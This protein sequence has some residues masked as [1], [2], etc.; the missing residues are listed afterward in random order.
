MPS[1][2]ATFLISQFPASYKPT[3]ARITELLGLND[4]NTTLASLVNVVNQPEAA[5]L[6]NEIMAMHGGKIVMVK[7]WT[8]LRVPGGELWETGGGKQ[9]AGFAVPDAVRD[10][11]KPEPR[12]DPFEF[13]DDAFE[14]DYGQM[15]GEPF[16]ALDGDFDR[17]NSKSRSLSRS[18]PSRSRSPSLA[19]SP[20]KKKYTAK[21]SLPLK[22]KSE[23][24]HV[25]EDEEEPAPK[26]AR[27][28]NS[29]TSAPPA[30]SK[31]K[32]PSPEP[33]SNSKGKQKETEAAPV[34]EKSATPAG[35]RGK[36][37][38]DEVIIALANRDALDEG[39]DVERTPG[40]LGT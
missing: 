36:E 18:P 25:S 34:K 40:G 31:P 19:P 22:R 11:P 9:P 28:S 29:R 3:I 32:Q 24:P 14:V 35:K 1:E 23:S 4:V 39:V 10:A 12:G 30:P 26:R 17:A 7:L 21:R 38:L 13:R 2:S 8:L 6:R 15:N 27:A 5:A 16:G 33:P 20:P 37:K